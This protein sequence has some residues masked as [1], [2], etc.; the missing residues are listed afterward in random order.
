M[1][2]VV[3]KVNNE[4]EADLFEIGKT[5]GLLAFLLGAGQRGQQQRRQNG[6]DRNDDQKFDQRKTTPEFVHAK[7]KL[8][9]DEIK[10]R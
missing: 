3:V 5:D 6:D 1:I 10:A 7:D 8:P 4:S 9:P 2:V